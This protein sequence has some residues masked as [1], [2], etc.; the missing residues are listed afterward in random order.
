[1]KK[2]ILLLLL[3]LC[4]LSGCGEKAPEEPVVCVPKEECF[5]CAGTWKRDNVGIISLNTFEIAEVELNRYDRD[6]TLIE[7]L[8]GVF[9]MRNWRFEEDDLHISMG[10]DVDRGHAFLTIT[11]GDDQKADRSKAAGFLCEDCLE[12]I[13]PEGGKEKMGFGAIDL[14]TGEIR[15][16][17]RQSVGFG[18]GDF[19]VHCD[20]EED[21]T[22]L[23]LLIFYVP[24]RY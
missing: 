24:L 15:A 8:S 19:F 23:K 2:R 12:E 3:A 11:P 18:V 16:F 14:A 5:V 7:E 13:L 4:L 21:E 6:G 1:M 22:E 9:T 17:D 10:L 20:W